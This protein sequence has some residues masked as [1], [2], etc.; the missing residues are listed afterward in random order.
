MPFYRPR[1]KSAGENVAPLI[2]IVFLL[3]IFFMVAG[4]MQ[5]DN[6]GQITPPASAHGESMQADANILGMNAAGE[7]FWRGERYLPTELAAADLPVLEQMT[8]LADEKTKAAALLRVLEILR[9]ADIGRVHLVTRA[10]Q[11]M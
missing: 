6:H 8:I 5:D 11:P 9:S 1:H 7:L 3:L 4:Q 10:E 2:N